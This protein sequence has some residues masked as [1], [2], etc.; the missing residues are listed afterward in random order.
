VALLNPD[1]DGQKDY[2]LRGGYQ[3]KLP[4]A[5]VFG[6]GSLTACRFRV[7]LKTIIRTGTIRRPCRPG[8]YWYVP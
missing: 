4:T 3:A 1:S 8:Q 6:L 5:Q 2:R 7:D